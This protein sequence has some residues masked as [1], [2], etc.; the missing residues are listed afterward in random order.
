MVIIVWVFALLAAL[1]HIVVF[2]WESL[3][4]HRPF[5]H[6]KVFAIPASDLPALRL[7]TFG[8]GFY[9][10]FLGLGLIVGVGLWAL[11]DA[12]RGQALV[13]FICCVLVLCGLVLFIA[14][15]LGMGRTKGS[16]IGGALSQS[17]P[18]LAALV[19]MAF[20]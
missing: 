18:P 9:N 17:A 5:V 10:L 12:V 6:E 19:G 11:G 15:R 16:G 4:L 1:I 13:V 8:L 3:L 14:D 7:W 20:L 2:A